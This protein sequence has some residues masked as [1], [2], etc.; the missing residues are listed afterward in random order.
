MVGRA[1]PEARVRR[2][3]HVE[4]R[5]VVRIGKLDLRDVAPVQFRCK[6]DQLQGY[7]RGT[8]LTF[9]YSVLAKRFRL[10]AERTSM[11]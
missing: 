5:Q 10:G 4:F 3:D 9:R 7:C 1:L 11:T 2:D 8:L 6:E